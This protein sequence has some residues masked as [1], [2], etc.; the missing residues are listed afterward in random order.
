MSERTD[1]GEVGV[2]LRAPAL[3][4]ALAGRLERMGYGALW[5]G[6]SPDPDLALVQAALDASERIAVAT[7]IVPIWA[8]PAQELA[9]AWHR[10]E[11]R[12]P[13]RFLLGLGT[14]H[15]ERWGAP[16]ERPVEALLEYVDAL[17][18]DG[19]PAQRMTLAALGPR[20]LR[21]SAE[22]T[23]GA[24]PFLVPVEHTRRARELIGSSAL[25]APEQRVVL[26]ADPERARAIA[27]PTV[28]TPYL[29]LVNYRNNLLRLGYTEADLADGGSDRL[30]DDLVGWG[31][32]A[33][34]A[35]RIRA[36]L[37]AGADHVCVQL[38][39]PDDAGYARIA[40]AL[41]L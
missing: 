15:R 11:A 24:H 22:R 27:R 16:A 40:A 38:L 13:G 2:W 34:V 30:I 36:Q 12:H 6:G 3:D 26:E 31:D 21:L 18:A 17:V 19:V 35:G 1:L 29:D 25:L 5:I 32:D 7:G 20:V 39:E 23:A 41:G 14:S 33:A 8:A 37:D 10:V 28:A 4:P 9:A